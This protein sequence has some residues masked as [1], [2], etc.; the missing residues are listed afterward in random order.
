MVNDPPYED[1]QEGRSNY[2]AEFSANVSELNT[3][4][5]GGYVYDW[6]TK[7]FALKTASKNTV[8]STSVSYT[9]LTLPT[10]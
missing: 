6:A 7:S 4:E 8:D 10:T 1:Y 3:A 2:P 5:F 9:Q